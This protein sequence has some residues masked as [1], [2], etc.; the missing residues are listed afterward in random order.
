MTSEAV[1]FRRHHDYKRHIPGESLTVQ[2]AALECDINNVVKRLLAGQDP[3]VPLN[4]GSYR[5]NTGH[6]D[7]KTNLD[8]IRRHQSAFNELPDEVRSKF[9]NPSEYYDA[10]HQALL[11][12]AGTSNPLDVSGPT[13]SNSVAV[14]SNSS[15]RKSSETKISRSK[16]GQKNLQE[17]DRG[18]PEE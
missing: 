3:G 18:E 1:R 17:G 4:N 15:G 5:D 14:S 11:Q 2:S 13:D 12:Q 10:Q 6:V 16:N 7:L 8:T 9:R